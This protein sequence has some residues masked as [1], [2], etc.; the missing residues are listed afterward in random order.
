MS[1]APKTICV[2][3]KWFHSFDYRCM[4]SRLPPF[5]ISPVTGKSVIIVKGQPP[6][7]RVVNHGDCRY[8]EEK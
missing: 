6:L 5:V 2:H 8:Y 7:C 1:N 3:C 4:S